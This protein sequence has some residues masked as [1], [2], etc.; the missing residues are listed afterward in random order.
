MNHCQICG[1]PIT[2]NCDDQDDWFMAA[3]YLLATIGAM[4]VLGFVGSILQN[5]F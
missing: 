4:C 2:C 5:L 3:V 1:T